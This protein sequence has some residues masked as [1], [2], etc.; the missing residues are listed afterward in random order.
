MFHT[1]FACLFAVDMSVVF[2]GVGD[3]CGDGVMGSGDDGGGV[4][5]A[6]HIQNKTIYCIFKVFTN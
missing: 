5:V 6:W 2:G 3:V 4:G 1:V